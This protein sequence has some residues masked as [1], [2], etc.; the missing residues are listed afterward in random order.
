MV[1][2]GAVLCSAQKLDLPISSPA[3]WGLVD[4]CC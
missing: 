3:R 1:M 2:N 4:G